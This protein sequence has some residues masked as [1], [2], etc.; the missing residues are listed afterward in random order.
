VKG[1]RG[2][3]LVE[4]LI[5]MAIVAILVSISMVMY[6]QVRLRGGETA[7]IAALESINQAQFAYMQTCGNQRYA[8]TLADLGKPV[9]GTKAGYLSPDL[10]REGEEIVKSGYIL[11][12]S[13]TPVSDGS[14]TCTGATPVSGYRLTADPTVPGVG[15]TRFFGTNTDRVIYEDIETFHPEMPEAGPPEHGKELP[16]TWGNPKS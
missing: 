14:Q 15:G 6:R 4:L 2:F 11:R 5:V 12:M 10:A 1:N 8:P 13:G 7:A 9:P 3:T 16:A